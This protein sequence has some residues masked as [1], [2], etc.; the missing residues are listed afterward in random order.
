MSKQAIAKKLVNS[1]LPSPAVYKQENVSAKYHNPNV[2]DGKGQW[3]HRTIDQILHNESYLGH[4]V[5]GRHKVKSYKIHT[6]VACDRDDW[7]IVEN[8]HEAIVEKATF[9]L[10][11]SLMQRDTRTAPKQKEVYTFSGFLKCADCG[12]GITRRASKGY[13]YYACKTYVHYSHD[14]CTRHSLKNTDLEKAVLDA[15]QN[16]IALV[17]GLAQ[18]VEEINNAPIIRTVSNRVNAQLKLR[19]QELEKT[20]RIKDEIYVDWKAGDINRDD[21][22]RMRKDFEDK[23]QSIRANLEELKEEVSDMSQGIQ[24]DNPYLTTFLK[25]KNVK[26]LDRGIVVDLIK[27]I[28]VHEGGAITIDFNFIDQHRRIVEFIENNHNDLTIISGR[29]AI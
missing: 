26:T 7:Y 22:H 9:E 19:T 4:M 20:I 14:L 10:A 29:E 23:E 1:G 2:A 13:V 12:R 28:S 27:A 24:S 21:Y 11:Q 8:T 17:D 3:S 15:I 25:Y 18:A 6:I 5:Q 16:Q